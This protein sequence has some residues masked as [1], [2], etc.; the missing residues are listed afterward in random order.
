MTHSLEEVI[1]MY[2]EIPLVGIGTTHSLLCNG[3]ETI[4]VSSPR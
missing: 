3:V 1:Q 4:C 2:R